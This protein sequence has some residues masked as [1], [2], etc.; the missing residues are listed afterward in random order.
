MAARAA[1]A[2]L[3]QFP[4]VSDHHHTTLQCLCSQLLTICNQLQEC[5]PGCVQN[6]CLVQWAGELLNT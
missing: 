5:W 6:M 4:I 3:L 1:V 2:G